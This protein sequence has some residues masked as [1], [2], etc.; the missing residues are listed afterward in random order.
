M[1]TKKTDG[2]SK[3]KAHI[4]EETREHYKKAHQEMREAVKGLLPEGF[5]EHRRVARREML[6]AV[7]SL[8]D[9]AI[10]RTED[11]A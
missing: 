11:K 2:E 5:M 8:L 7:R 3:F 6:L 1:A 9:A 4:P 10:E